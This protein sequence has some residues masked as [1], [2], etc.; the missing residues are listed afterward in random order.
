MTCASILGAQTLLFAETET[1]VLREQMLLCTVHRYYCVRSTVASV[2][3]AQIL[4]FLEHSG[5]CA[6]ST[7]TTVF[8][9][10]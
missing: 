1:I 8:G 10:Q 2:L 7:D 5:I 6:L 9:A 3:G 4:L